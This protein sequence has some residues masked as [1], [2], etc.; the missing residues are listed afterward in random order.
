MSK[1]KKNSRERW[2]KNW[3]VKKMNNKKWQTAVV[4]RKR[5]RE[6]G[7]EGRH[8]RNFKLTKLW[9]N[10]RTDKDRRNAENPVIEKIH[11]FSEKGFVDQQND[12]QLQFL[13]YHPTFPPTPSNCHTFFPRT[14]VS[15]FRTSLILILIKQSHC[16]QFYNLT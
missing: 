3:S 7:G 13:L 1:K 10:A 16:P 15:L 8:D 2:E 14:F 12:S 11:V 9:K 6:R 5:E 4:K